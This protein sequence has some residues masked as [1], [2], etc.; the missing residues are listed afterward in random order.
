[1]PNTLWQMRRGDCCVVVGFDPALREAYRRRLIELGFRPGVSISCVVAPS[2]GA[3]KLF[4]VASS[5]FSL[6]R[7]LAQRVLINEARP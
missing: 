3:P 4:Q 2:F 6:E 5:V 7:D 1:M